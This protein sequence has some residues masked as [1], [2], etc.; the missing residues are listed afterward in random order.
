MGLTPQQTRDPEVERVRNALFEVL[1]PEAGQLFD[2]QN[3][4]LLKQL[5]QMQES[6]TFG[7]LTGM[8]DSYWQRHANTAA[9]NAVAAYAKAAGI[10]AEQLP[11]N[12]M[13]RM[14]RLLQL[15]IEED[16]TGRRQWRFEN[17]DPSL[18]DEFMQE[19]SGMFINPMRTAA[20]R[21]TAQ[22]VQINRG[23]PDTTGGGNIPGNGAGAAGDPP[24]RLRG[25]DL[26]EAA[27]NFVLQ[28][29]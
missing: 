2:P 22:Q 8:R 16:E 23:L 11:P 10:E 12:T 4:Q 5:R 20:T 28:N 14:A 6:G 26:R 24:Q 29:R 21:N 17:D 27:R 7:E 19:I 18:M 3:I 9:R 25:K 1:G 13:I 15:H